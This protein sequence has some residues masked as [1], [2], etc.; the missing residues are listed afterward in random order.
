MAVHVKCNANLDGKAGVINNSIHYMPCQIHAD[1][2]ANVSK[3]FKPYIKK[4]DEDGD[5]M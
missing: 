4:Q 2:E 3:Y 5:G 1:G